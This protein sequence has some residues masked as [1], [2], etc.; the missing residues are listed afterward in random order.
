MISSAA[1]EYSPLSYLMDLLSNL[2]ADWGNPTQTVAPIA[3]PAFTLSS[4]SESKVVNTAIS[5][6]SISSS[7]GA[8]A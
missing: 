3:A 4:S 2:P 1:V 5:G 7:G 6:Y 8:I